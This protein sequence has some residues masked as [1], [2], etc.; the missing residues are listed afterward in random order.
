M[1]KWKCWQVDNISV[2]P[3]SVKIM[4]SLGVVVIPIPVV[5]SVMVTYIIPLYN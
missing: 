3:V 2:I 1:M 5:V 4:T